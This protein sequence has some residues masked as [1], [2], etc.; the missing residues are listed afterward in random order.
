MKSTSELFGGYN[1][2]SKSAARNRKEELVAQIVDCT[3]A[4]GEKAKS[5]LRRKLCITY[6]TL[7]WTEYD[8]E[9]LL[10]KADGVKN[11]G[12]KNFSAYVNSVVRVINK[13]N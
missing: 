4:R 6:N 8:L 12:I 13:T 5:A 9:I 7:K 1:L 10:S 3:D 11:P 2:P